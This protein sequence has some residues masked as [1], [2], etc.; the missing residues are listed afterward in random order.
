MPK[1]AS[2]VCGVVPLFRQRGKIV[3]SKKQDCKR[4]ETRQKRQEI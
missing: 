4:R 2:G 1:Y 3:R